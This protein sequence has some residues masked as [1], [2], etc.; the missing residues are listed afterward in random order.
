M[1]ADDHAVVRRGLRQ[2]LSETEDIQVV[3]EAS[4]ADEVRAQA[5][6]L[7]WDVLVLDMNMPGGSSFDLL[8]DVR[9]QDPKAKVLVLTMFQEEQYGVRCIRAGASGFLSKESAPEK[10]LEAVRKLAHGGKYISVEL[11]EA[12]ASAVAGETDG[13]PH[14]RLSD[15]EMEVFR[16]LASGRTVSQIAEAL[17]LSVKTVSTHRTRILKKM[18]MG[19]NAELMRYALKNG[20]A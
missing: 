12:L 8:K 15:R 5:Q 4:N 7:R 19:S 17:S 18:G 1:I 6:E 20:L 2:I 3:G 11:A 9:T 16:Q 13:N 14:D 10:L